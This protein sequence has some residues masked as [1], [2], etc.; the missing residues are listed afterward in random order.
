MKG[1]A[2]RSGLIWWL[3]ALILAGLAGVLTFRLLTTASPMALNAAEHTETQLVVVAASDIPFRRSITEE[4][5]VVRK[6]PVESVPEGAALSVEQVIGKMST[7]DLFAGEPVIIQQLVTPGIVTSQ[8]ALSIPD[9]KTVMAVP[10]GSELIGNR[11]VRPGD[12]I[13]L[14]GTFEMNMNAGNSPASMLESVALLQGLEVHAIILPVKVDD[15]NPVSTKSSEEPQDDESGVFRTFNQLGQSVLL[16]VD[17]QDALVI[18]HVLDA[19]G[20][21]D[22]VLRAPEDDSLTET[23]PVDQNY[24]ADRYRINTNHFNTVGLLPDPVE[25]GE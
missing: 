8:L 9:S 4:D 7:V 11:L 25:Q 5:L 24:L 1:N 22:L 3:S 16:A 12:Q 6:F 10:T 21:V 2:I 23:V 19:G 18:R 14:L 15:R 20:T 13:D 17:V